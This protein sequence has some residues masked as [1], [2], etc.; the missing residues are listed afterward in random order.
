M[1]T[2]FIVKIGQKSK[3]YYTSNI[4][5]VKKRPCNN[6]ILADIGFGRSKMVDICLSHPDWR[7]GKPI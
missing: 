6:P 4:S 2:Y 1:I 7:P 3:T 5:C